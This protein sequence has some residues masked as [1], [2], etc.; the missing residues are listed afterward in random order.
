M[1]GGS[2]M[3]V[4]SDNIMHPPTMPRSFPCIYQEVLTRGNDNKIIHPL[5]EITA[6]ADPAAPSWSQQRL[7]TYRVSEQV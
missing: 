3:V 4:I 2:L 5:S 1:I 7:K 6:V